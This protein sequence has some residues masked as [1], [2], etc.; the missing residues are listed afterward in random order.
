[1]DYP[2]LFR[3]RVAQ[4][5]DH[6]IALEVDHAEGPFIYTKD[7]GQ[8]IDFISGIAV[9]NLGHRH[10]KVVKA[11]KEQVDRYLHVMVY[12]EFVQEPQVQFA[13][14]LADQL[15]ASLE[16]VYFVNSGTEA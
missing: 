2:S 5:S 3:N 11:I 9:N 4:T 1:M 15:P 7:G 13:K 16:Q 12:G 8:Y 6:P 10:P 14:L